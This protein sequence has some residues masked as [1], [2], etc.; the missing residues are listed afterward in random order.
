MRRWTSRCEVLSTFRRPPDLRPALRAKRP[1]VPVPS[2]SCPRPEG[3]GS[4]A[5][6]RF[7]VAAA[8]SVL[9]SVRCRVLAAGGV[10][11]WV[12][13]RGRSRM[14]RSALFFSL[15]VV[16][17]GGDARQHEAEGEVPVLALRDHGR[18]PI[19]RSAQMLWA[20]L[21]RHATTS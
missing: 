15:K 14:A 19:A 7:R 1:L 2:L 4:T 20:S 17:G 6:S 8:A 18:F 13:R 3:G 5:R 16:K 11:S 12:A 9:G 21:A 10:P